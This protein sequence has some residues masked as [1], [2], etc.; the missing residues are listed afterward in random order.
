M[1]K[2][3]FETRGVDIESVLMFDALQSTD[4]HFVDVDMD[5]K[6]ESN[7]YGSDDENYQHD[8]D[9]QKGYIELLTTTHNDMGHSAPWM[10]SE[11]PQLHYETGVDIVLNF[12][13][14]DAG[15]MEKVMLQNEYT[16]DLE[17]SQLFEKKSMS[18]KL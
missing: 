2:L 1:H 13:P 3:T 5:S 16:K 12:D 8:T 10:N 11:R 9:G 7:L 18:D 14:L 15:G 17:L 4:V 6:L